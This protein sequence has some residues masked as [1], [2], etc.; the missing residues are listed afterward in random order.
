VI[1]DAADHHQQR[2]NDVAQFPFRAEI[3]FD[4][5]VVPATAAV[6]VFVAAAAAV[7]V[8]VVAA[9]AVLVVAA[10]A[11]FVVVVTMFVAHN[12]LS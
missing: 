12:T 8:F 4:A 11:V 5:V 1:D 6:A 9:V 10:V 7:A 3:L 2:R